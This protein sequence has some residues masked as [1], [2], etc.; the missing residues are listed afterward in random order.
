MPWPFIALVAFIFAGILLMVI[1]GFRRNGNILGWPTS[2]PRPSY[3]QG[4]VE[5]IRQ[6]APVPLVVQWKGDCVV[7]QDSPGQIL[8]LR[9]SHKS[10]LLAK[11]LLM[12]IGAGVFLWLAALVPATPTR[13]LLFVIG[14]GALIAALR[15]QLRERTPESILFQADQDYVLATSKGVSQ[16]VAIREFSNIEA[17]SG[18]NTWTI[19]MRRRNGEIW[20]LAR[21]N[22]LPYDQSFPMCATLINS[23]V[24]LTKLPLEVTYPSADD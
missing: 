14:I 1:V 9:S 17:M 6:Q 4:I 5:R 2:K 21:S 8:E 22:P 20:M 3:T 10:F 11:V 15:E 24:N 16:Q 18:R 23:V 12:L 19:Y 7:A 13:V